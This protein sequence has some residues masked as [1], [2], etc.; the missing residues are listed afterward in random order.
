[1]QICR[2]LAVSFFRP[3]TVESTQKITDGTITPPQ[4]DGLMY[5]SRGGGMRFYR[6]LL[7]VG[8]AVAVVPHGAVYADLNYR[9]EI[10]GAPIYWTKSPS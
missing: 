4:H 7:T 2:F 9:G 3:Q 6:F 5:R 10:M 8:L 1:M